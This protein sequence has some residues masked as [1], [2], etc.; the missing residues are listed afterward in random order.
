MVN[1]PAMFSLRAYEASDNVN[2]IFRLGKL[3]NKYH[4]NEIVQQMIELMN[5]TI[6]IEI[7]YMSQLI[8][9]LN[10]I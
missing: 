1:L 9:I 5:Q 8:N 7:D 4:S 3:Y 2:E 10:L 6:D